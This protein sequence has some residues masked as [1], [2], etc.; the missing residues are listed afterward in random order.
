MKNMKRW[1]AL[2]M[3]MVMVLGLAGCTGKGKTEDKD[4]E[5]TQTLTVAV[6]ADDVEVRIMSAFIKAYKEQPGNENKDIKIVK[7]NELYDSW[8]N[9][10][11]YVEKLAD[12]I[13]VFDYSAEFWTNFDL[14]Q[15]ISSYM[16]RDGVNEEDYYPS[17]IE[18]AKSKTGDNSMYWVPRDYNK[19]VVCYN[20]KMFELA[21]VEKPSDDWTF[22]DFHETCKKLQAAEDTITDYTGLSKIW[23]VDMGLNWTATYYPVIKS[24]GGGLIDQEKGETFENLDAVKTGFESLLKYVDEGLCV[25]PD[26][27]AAPFINRQCAMVFTSRPNVAEYFEYLEGEIDFA[28]FPTISGVETSY[29]GMGCTGYGITRLCPDEKKELAWDFL[30]FIISEEGQNAFSETGSCIPSLKALADDENATFRTVYPGL[31][32]DA[33][34]KYPERD[35]PMNYMKG[36]KPDKQLGIYSYINSN[37]LSTFVDLTGADRENRYMEFKAELEEKF[38]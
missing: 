27:A 35:I 38:K 25:A 16:E 5:E 9:K 21:G 34:V 37:L 3:S 13:Q 28:S 29:I 26:D 8:V 30:K 20:T 14:L 1:I 2:L 33:F 24:Y 18:M 31:N 4:S 12:I 10:Q 15:P 22:E 17:V 36:F 7:I 19:V 32:H 6:S 11:L 23:A